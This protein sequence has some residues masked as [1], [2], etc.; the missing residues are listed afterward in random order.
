MSDLLFARRGLTLADFYRNQK[1]LHEST[2]IELNSQ[3]DDYDLGLEM[4]V[5][6]VDRGGDAH[7]YQIFNPGVALPQDALAFACSGTGQRHADVVFAYRKYT[8][9]FSLERAVYVSFEAKKK[10]EMAGGVGASTDIAI[11][12]NDA[13]YRLLPQSVI[14]ELERIYSES[15]KKSKIDKEIDEAIKCLSLGSN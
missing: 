1:T 11:I 4:I 12:K 14:M 7:V 8:P 9:T 6:G 5:V 15:E 2:I 10:A 13:T 3:M